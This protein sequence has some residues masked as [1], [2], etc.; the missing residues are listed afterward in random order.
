MMMKKMCILPLSI[1]KMTCRNN[2]HSVVICDP[3]IR[4]FLKM[5]HPHHRMVF[6]WVLVMGLPRAGVEPKPGYHPF[7][8]K[9][10]HFFKVFK[11]FSIT[12]TN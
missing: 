3:N 12:S 11:V 9:H 5:G 2:K 6:W 4:V 10:E 1:D 7:L 8:E